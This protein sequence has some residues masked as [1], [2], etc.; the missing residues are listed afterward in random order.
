MERDLCQI[1]LMGIADHMRDAGQCR[2]L[3]GRALSVTSRDNDLTIGIVTA[4]AANGSAG[5]L[6]GGG[7]NR[8]GIE[9][10]PLGLSRGIGPLHAL[11]HELTLNGGTVRLSGPAAEIFYVKAGHA[12]ILAYIH[13]R[14]RNPLD[15]QRCASC[16]R[17]LNE[18]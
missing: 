4:N 2:D 18:A 7:G 17:G 8:T 15:P 3:F 12:T 9:N 11:I 1:V 10:D 6:F 14:M 16:V 13:L 5:I